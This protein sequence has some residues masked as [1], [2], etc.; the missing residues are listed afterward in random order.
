MKELLYFGRFAFYV[1]RTDLQE[2]GATGLERY[3]GEIYEE[4]LPELRG[5]RGRRLIRQMIDN[6]ATIGSLL[7]AIE[8][9]VRQVTWDVMPATDSSEDVEAADFIKSALFEDM[10]H[11]W[12]DTLA[13]ILSFLPWGWAYFELVYKVR[14]GPETSDSRKR[15]KFTDGRIGWR[16][17]AIRSQESLDRWEFDESG[18]VKAMCQQPA[19]DFTFR[20]IPIEKA[21]L[22]RTTSRKGNPEGFPIIRRAYSS[23]YFKTNIQR[24]EGVG[25][26]RDLAGLPVAYVPP[27]LLS[28]TATTDQQAVL[29][30]V[31]K[32]VTNI[33]RDEQE[34]VIFPLIYDQAGKEMYRLELM[35]SGGSRQ[36]DT[37]KVI[38][39]Y[40][41]RIL[42]SVLADFLLLGS[43]KVGSFALSSNKTSLF[44]VALGAWLDSICDVVNRFAIPRLLKLNAMPA[45]SAPKLT[46]GD[47]ED[48]SLEELANYVSTLSS[49]GIPF[50][51]PE[52]V[53]HLYG[54]ARLPV[55]AE[56]FEA[57]GFEAEG[58]EPKEESAPPEDEQAT[59]EE[60]Q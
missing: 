12:S 9:L 35:S 5:R 15:S 26:E 1:A 42:M 24:I 52:V 40:D 48:F 3:A 8:M 16:K 17:W 46:H 58:L 37:D 10:S 34:G 44:S 50:N 51:S 25:I 14:Q 33:R 45:A 59:E 41:Q 49:A 32:I 29:A 28:S 23:W 20:T 27:E 55:P 56:G 6:D 31:K 53:T 2:F 57:E 60:T 4:I 43:E 21:L 38:A 47:V 7:F 19:P 30:E 13:E 11:S 54:K 22:F 18:G 39:R 36:F